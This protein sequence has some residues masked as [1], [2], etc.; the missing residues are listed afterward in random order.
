M[1]KVDRDAYASALDRAYG[2]AQGRITETVGKAHDFATREYE[3]GQFTSYGALLEGVVAAHRGAIESVVEALIAV[4]AQAGEGDAASITERLRG[5]IDGQ[6]EPSFPGSGVPHEARPLAMA[7]ESSKNALVTLSSGIADKVSLALVA[8][9]SEN[10]E[11]K[12]LTRWIQSHPGAVWILLVGG[13]LLAARGLYEVGC[14]VYT[15]VAG[16]LGP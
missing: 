4:H 12:V 1:P 3:S 14:D 8:E 15:W 10:A 7:R 11:F 9:R 13:S 6:P 2:R 16:Q 5:F